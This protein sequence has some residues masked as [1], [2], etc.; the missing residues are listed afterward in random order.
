MKKSKF[1]F[2]NYKTSGT[3][4]TQEIAIPAAL[5]KIIKKWLPLIPEGTNHLLFNANREPLT[6]VT[7]NQRLTEIFGPKRGVN[8]IRH[9]YLT[10]NHAETIRGEDNLSADMRAMGS[11]INQA[12]SYIK[13]NPKDIEAKV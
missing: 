8:S 3:Y 5:K 11:N 2:N 10:E 9:L 12:R 13:I 4:G 7:L 1:V 6:N